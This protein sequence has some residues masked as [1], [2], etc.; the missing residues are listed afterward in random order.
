MF[1]LCRLRH[2]LVPSVENYPMG[3]I[4]AGSTRRS[5]TSPLFAHHG[6]DPSD[7]H[8]LSYTT[9]LF[10]DKVRLRRFHIPCNAVNT[11]SRQK[12]LPTTLFAIDTVPE[13]HIRVI[14]RWSMAVLAFYITI[15]ETRWNSNFSPESCR[16][17]VYF[18]PDFLRISAHVFQQGQIQTNTFF[19]ASKQFKKIVRDNGMSSPPLFAVLNCF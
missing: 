18:Q 14:C 19:S 9:V 12:T 8:Q 10:W 5:G 16:K 7:V 6:Y 13:I 3:F 11:H 1:S 15:P 17:V 2:I 4:I